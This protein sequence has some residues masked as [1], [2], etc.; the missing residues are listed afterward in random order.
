[1]AGGMAGLQQGIAA[2][3][4]ARNAANS[5]HHTIGLGSKDQ[6]ATASSGGGASTSSGVSMQDAKNMMAQAP[7]LGNL[8]ANGMPQLR[9]AADRAG[10]ELRRACRFFQSKPLPR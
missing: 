7:Q 5:L 9:K 1:M 8:F 2:M 4:S 3:A 10:G 6:A